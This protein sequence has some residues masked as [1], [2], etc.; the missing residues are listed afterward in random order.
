[1]PAERHHPA[2]RQ[3][4]SAGGVVVSSRGRIV[5]VGQVTRS[6]SL[7]KGHVEPG[8]SVLESAQRE[9]AEETGLIVGSP[10]KKFPPYTRRSGR[11]PREFKTIVMFLFV[12]DDE[13]EPN[14]VDPGNSNARWLDY[15]GAVEALTYREDR[16]FLRSI[17]SDLRAISSAR[18]SPP[19]GPSRPGSGGV[20]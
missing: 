3:T 10:L 1:M 7:P 4:T 5:V 6:D 11:T 17:E 13:P 18:T 14:P 20:A 8:E 9:I 12:L 2:E 19:S 15:E 16:T